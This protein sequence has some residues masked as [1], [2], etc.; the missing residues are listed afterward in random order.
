MAPFEALYGRRCR[1]PIG[2]FK[3]GEIAFLGPELVHEAMEKVQLIREK[4]KM[5]Q[6]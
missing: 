6:S 2:W 4:L 1:S 5:A 3:F